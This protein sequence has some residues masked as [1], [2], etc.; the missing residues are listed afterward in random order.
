MTK[1]MWINL[2]VKN[3]TKARDFFVAIGFQA[4]EGP[5]NS[6]HSASIKIGSKNSILMLFEQNFFKTI[7]GNE[8]TDTSKSSEVL[9][10]F[11]AESEEEVREIAAK[12]EKA[13]GTVFSK[14]AAFQ[15]WMYGCAFCDP[16]GH[17]WNVLFMDFS[18]MK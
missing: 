1:D 12:V 11:D 8:C 18:K 4:N 9:F 2:P 13:G 17:R 10:S 14:P 15:G 6:E 7:S 3:V 16:D 5:G